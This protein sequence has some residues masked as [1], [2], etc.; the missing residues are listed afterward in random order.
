VVYSQC[1]YGTIEPV[2]F[3]TKLWQ[4]MGVISSANMTLEALQ[5]KV[6]WLL[7]QNPDSSLFKQQMQTAICGEIG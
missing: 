3:S 7:A 4:D 2:Y 6:M 5:V 1:V